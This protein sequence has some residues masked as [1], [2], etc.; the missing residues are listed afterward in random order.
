MR[1]FNVWQIEP[2]KVVANSVRA[3]KFVKGIITDFCA[4]GVVDNHTTLLATPNG[5]SFH[6]SA[7][8]PISSQTPMLLFW[9]W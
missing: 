7:S 8:H 6:S 1:I 3:K 4:L 2:C 9:Q 5:T